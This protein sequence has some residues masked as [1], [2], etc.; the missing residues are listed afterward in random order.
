MKFVRRLNDIFVRKLGFPDLSSLR[1]QM[2]DFSGNGS[3]VR[4]GFSYAFEGEFT[5]NR[6]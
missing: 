4:A 3:E 1:S 5:P 6:D 2:F